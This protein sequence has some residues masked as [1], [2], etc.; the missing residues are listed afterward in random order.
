MHKYL[1]KKHTHTQTQK[2]IY[3]E[4]YIYIEP[5]MVE[6]KENKIKINIKFNKTKNEVNETTTIKNNKQLFLLLYIVIMNKN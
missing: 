3:T 6:W 1:K 4:K 2:Y 5:N